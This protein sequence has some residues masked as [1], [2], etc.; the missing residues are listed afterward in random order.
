MAA[1]VREVHRRFPTGVTVVTTCVDR[2]PYGLAVNAFSSI[3]I[4]P[5]AVL[6]CVAQTSTTHPRLYASDW[7]AVNILAT[8][9]LD[10]AGRFATSGGDKFAG[11]EWEPGS[12]GAPVLRGVAAFLELEVERRIVAYTHT[13]F[14]GRVHHAAVSE[15]RPLTYLGGAFYAVDSLTPL[16]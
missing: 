12:S 11:L 3:S 14:I 10:V 15:R 13:I 6:V 9:Q 1:V 4:D 16:P 7:L 5:P 2:K 8:D